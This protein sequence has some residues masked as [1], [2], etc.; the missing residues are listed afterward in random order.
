MST[1]FLYTGFGDVVLIYTDVSSKLWQ[2]R[3]VLYHH[4][5]YPERFFSSCIP[6]EVS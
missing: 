2:R 6:F 5:V 1:G 4:E 3:N